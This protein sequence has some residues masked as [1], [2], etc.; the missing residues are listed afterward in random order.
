MQIKAYTNVDWAGSVVN[1]RS[2]SGYYTLVGGNLVTW[3]SKKRSVL[4]R[5]SA[6]T[7]FRS[8]ALGICEMM[9]IKRFLEELKVSTSSPMKLY[10]DNKA[11]IAIAHNPILH[12]RTKHVE[13]DKHFIKEKINTGLICMLYVPISSQV[14][15]ILT[16][17][18]HRHNLT[19]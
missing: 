4:A 1:K 9:W 12:D 5:S 15:N 16:K 11:T 8:V 13:V 3:S 17:R 10:C 14:V 2:T 6:E 19:V 18:L 7:E